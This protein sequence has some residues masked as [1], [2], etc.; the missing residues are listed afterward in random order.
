MIPFVL[1]VASI[2]ASSNVPT[3]QPAIYRPGIDVYVVDD[4][5]ID[6]QWRIGGAIRQL[7]TVAP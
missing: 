7:P 4:L 2:S 5:F 6:P 3:S 1:A